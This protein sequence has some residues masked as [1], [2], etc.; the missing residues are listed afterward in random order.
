[1]DLEKEIE[2]VLRNGSKFLVEREIESIKNNILNL[3][4]RYIA[5]EN[6]QKPF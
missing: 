1:M 2:E 5:D 4:K 3:M 6:M